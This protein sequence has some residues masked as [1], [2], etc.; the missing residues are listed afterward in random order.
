MD[1]VNA[2][3]TQAQGHSTSG[4]RPL[5]WKVLR[6]ASQDDNDPEKKKIKVRVYHHKLK[7]Y[8]NDFNKFN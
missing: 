5:L 4:L 7:Q 8:N 3:D 2:S 6:N 1:T